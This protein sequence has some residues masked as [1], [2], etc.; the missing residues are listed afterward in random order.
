[1][2]TKQFLSLALLLVIFV[3]TDA[4]QTVPSS[5]DILEK[6]YKQA[7]LENKNVFVIFHASWCGWCHKMDTSLNDITC[8]K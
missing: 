4:Q 6:A 3:T 8:T 2:K 5:G 7:R 1:M